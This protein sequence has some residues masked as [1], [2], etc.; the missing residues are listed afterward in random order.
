MFAIPD[1]CITSKATQSMAVESLARTVIQFPP[2]RLNQA[3]L[4][5]GWYLFTQGRFFLPDTKKPWYFT[6]MF[7][8]KPVYAVDVDMRVSEGR[9]FSKRIVNLHI[10]RIVCRVHD[11]G[12]NKRSFSNVKRLFC[13]HGCEYGWQR[14]C[15]VIPSEMP[16]VHFCYLPMRGWTFWT[17]N[18]IKAWRTGTKY[19]PP[20][21]MP[22]YKASLP[23]CRERCCRWSNRFLVL[24]FWVTLRVSGN[25]EGKRC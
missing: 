15:A 18:K 1:R 20:E 24:R 14:V 19:R 13:A 11:F 21:E 2:E 23:R 3:H 12:N 6:I 8:K 17:S 10:F 4:K 25:T 16:C 7:V 22:V 5:P 9:V